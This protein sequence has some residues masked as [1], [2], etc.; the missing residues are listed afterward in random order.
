MLSY[1]HI[2]HAG[3]LADVQKHAALAVALDYL[4]Q[5]NKPLTYMESHAG[6]GL[7]LLDAPE[8]L[9]TGEAAQGIEKVAHWFAD[10]HPYARAIAA[11]RRDHGPRAYPGSPLIA[12]QIL[13][14]LDTLHL[15]DLHPR[16]NVALQNAIA[17]FGARIHQKDGFDMALSLT[18]PDPRRGLLLIDPSY[19]IRS[20]YAAIPG[21]IAAI[22]RKW[23]VG[24]I[25][26]WYPILSDAP[27]LPMLQ[28][29][30]DDFPDALRHEVTFPPAREGHRMVGSG[31]FILNPP[32]GLIP[33]LERLSGL[34][35]QL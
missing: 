21:K 23:P 13:R 30:A 27:H 2:Y 12:A 6:R 20:D 4:T 34:F 5:K 35:A 11:T 28:A 17:P 24:I 9:K 25:M 31:L 32:Y 3:N 10:G 8:A 15:A 22:A 1:Q 18:P 19:E 16:E 33:E 29:L 14:D 7:Y 26:L